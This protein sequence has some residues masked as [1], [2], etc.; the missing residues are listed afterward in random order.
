MDE[1]LCKITAHKLEH[2]NKLLSHIAR[3]WYMLKN[4]EWLNFPI[5]ELINAFVDT[6]MN[7]WVDGW[8]N[9]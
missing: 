8:M 4:T 5:N 7:N 3:I 6:R 9:R 1:K 2:K